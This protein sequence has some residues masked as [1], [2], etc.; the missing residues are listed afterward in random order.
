MPVTTAA[1]R[2]LASGTIRLAILL[3]R[4]ATAISQSSADGADSAVQAQLAAE[5]KVWQLTLEQAVLRAEDPH[6]HRQIKS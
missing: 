5:Y 2:A 6:C 1:S 4:A 3:A